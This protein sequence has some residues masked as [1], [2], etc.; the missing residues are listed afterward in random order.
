MGLVLATLSDYCLYLSLFGWNGI[1]YGSLEPSTPQ[2]GPCEVACSETV[3]ANSLVS[4]A[5]KVISGNRRI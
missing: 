5:F 1:E 2:K 3:V 4:L